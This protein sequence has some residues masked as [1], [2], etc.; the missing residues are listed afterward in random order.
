[1][2]QRA[3]VALG[4]V[5]GVAYGKSPE[6]LL[7]Q[8]HRELRSLQAQEP[9]SATL[10]AV[11]LAS[12]LFYAAE[13]GKNPKVESFYD[14]LIYVST[15]ISVGYSDILARTSLGKVIGSALMT[16][17]PAFATRTLDAPGGEVQPVATDATLRELGAKL[18]RIL[19][20]I[21]SQRAAHADRER[22]AT[23]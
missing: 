5:L 10:K 2:D 7:S 19:A 11:V 8:A 21:V 4:V 18:D 17:G 9:A 22:P 23:L 14:A 3:L 12:I 13:R 6:T 15:N 1:M 16:Y 20:E